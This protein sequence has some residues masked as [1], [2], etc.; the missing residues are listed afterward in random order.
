MRSATL[1][2]LHHV[3][4]GQLPE[5]VVMPTL[6]LTSVG[7]WWLVVDNASS[8]SPHVG[9]VARVIA[10]ALAFFAGAVFLLK[11]IPTFVRLATP[12]YDLAAWWRSA[13]PLL[14]LQGIG[15]INLQT[16]I[17]MLAAIS[18]SESAGIYQAAVRGAELVAFALVIV[19]MAIQPTIS[20]LY[21]SGDMVR[22]QRLTTLA[23]RAAVA[24]ALPLAILMIFLGK[25]LMALVFGGDFA[26]GAVALAILAA[27]QL[28]NAATGSVNDLLNMTGHERDTAVGMAIGAIANVAL[29]FLLIPIWDMAGAAVAT[30]L[31][32]ILWNL[33]LV[34]MVRRRLG[35]AATALGRVHAPK[36]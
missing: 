24:A 10:A 9:V 32:L 18:G 11:R 34:V 29:N 1:R 6:F 4:L 5:N 31:S 20:R 7:L 19:N 28:I 23:A 33:W 2:G 17:L 16:D 21:A 27:A 35:L 25:P 14:F 30:G 13:L 22:L 26:R 3:L 8:L 12:Q 36:P 15:V